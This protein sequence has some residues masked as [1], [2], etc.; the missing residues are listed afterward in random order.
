MG[1]PAGEDEKALRV[2]FAERDTALAEIERL[3]EIADA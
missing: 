1:M 2:M 3:K